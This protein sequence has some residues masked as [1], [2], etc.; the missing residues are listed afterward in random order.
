M[1]DALMS[2]ENALMLLDP[3]SWLDLLRGILTHGRLHRFIWS[4]APTGYEVER[5]LRDRGI[6]C[7]GRM[8]Q[9]YRDGERKRLRRWCWVNQRQANF[10]EYNL[11]GAG[12]LLESPAVNPANWRRFGQGAARP[13]WREAGSVLRPNLIE[14]ISDWMEGFLR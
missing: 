3:A 14:A 10:A 6:H 7:Y 12:V 9:H 8:C 13:T 4:D 2:I 1:S 11:L 5:L